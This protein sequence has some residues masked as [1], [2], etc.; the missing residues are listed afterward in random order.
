MEGGLRQRSVR[1]GIVKAKGMEAG[2]G[3][4]VLCGIRLRA[5][6]VGG[7]VGETML[8]GRGRVVCEWMRSR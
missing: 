8:E 5:D 1:E 7:G 6:I 3:C 4:E 2:D